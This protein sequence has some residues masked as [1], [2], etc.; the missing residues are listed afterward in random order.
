MEEGRSPESCLISPEVLQASSETS[1]LRRIC[2]EA[3]IH[4]IP[5]HK[6]PSDICFPKTPVSCSPHPD[7][8]NQIEVISSTPL[9]DPEPEDPISLMLEPE[10]CDSPQ[11][12]ESSDPLDVLNPSEIAKISS[13]ADLVR[14][15]VY[16]KIS[17]DPSDLTYPML[18]DT[19]ASRSLISD[20]VLTRLPNATISP[21]PIKALQGIG[22]NLIPTSEQVSLTLKFSGN[23]VCSP[24]DFIITSEVC[25]TYSL[26]LGADFLKKN[27]FL[28]DVDQKTLL[29]KRDD[30][31]GIVARDPRQ[32]TKLSF[33]CSA[34]ESL[35]ISP[36]SFKILPI[37]LELDGFPEFPGYR[38]LGEFEQIPELPV[39][40]PPGVVFLTPESQSVPVFNP[41]NKIRHLCKGQEIGFV[42][43]LP[44]EFM[45][46]CDSVATVS[47]APVPDSVPQIWTSSL[48]DENFHLSH[49]SDDQK[50]PLIKLLLKFPEAMSF[51]D[52]DVGT[53]SAIK[54]HIEVTDPKP[55]SLP[56]R[57]LTPNV[58]EEVDRECR[59]L[60]EAGIVQKSFSPYSAPIVPIRKPDG[61]LRLCIDYRQ[62]NRVTKKDKFPL[63]NLTDLIYSLH[64][65]KY[66][67]SIDLVRGYYQVLMDE[68][69]IE[70]TAFST[71][72][73]HLEFTR[74]PFGV[75]NGPATFQRGMAIALAG[76][77]SSRA[78]VYLDD[79]LVMGQ[80]FEDHLISLEMVLSAL[81]EHGFKL[82]P[83][84]TSLAL[85]E[86]QF[87]GHL[88]SSSGIKPLPKNLSG[89]QEFP[90]PNTVRQVR[91]FLGMVNFY[92]R[93]IPRCAEISKPL[94][95]ITGQKKLTWTNHCQEAFDQLKS[96][97]QSPILLTYPNFS[98]SDSP[99]EL[100][101]D[102]SDLGAG[103]VLSQTQESVNRPIAFVSCTFNPAQKRY[104]TTEKEL[105]AL[106]W[107]VK[108]LRVFLHGAKFILYTDHRPLIYLHNMKLES[109]RLA[110]TV[111]DLSEFDY[112]LRYTPGVTNTVADALSRNPIG[113]SESP[114]IICPNHPPLEFNLVPIPGGGNSLFTCLAQWKYRDPQ[115]HIDI[116]E[117]VF[118]KILDSPEKFGFTKKASCLRSLRIQRRSGQLVPEALCHVLSEVLEMQIQVY[119]GPTNPMVYGSPSVDDKCYLFCQA[120]I[121]YDLLYPTKF[122]TP[123]L[124][125]TS[126]TSPVEVLHHL[127]DDDLPSQDLDLNISPEKNNSESPVLFPEETSEIACIGSLSC[128]YPL[129]DE[130]TL[131]FHQKADRQVKELYSA[132][133][134]SL[135]VPNWSPRL[136]PFR[137]MSSRFEITDGL[138]VYRIPQSTS[139]PVIPRTLLIRVVTTYHVDQ[140]HLGRDKLVALIRAQYWSPYI[141][142]VISDICSACPTCQTTKIT[143]VMISPPM[144]KIQCSYPFEL[145]SMDLLNL[146]ITPRRFCCCL[147]IIDHF[148][149][150]LSVVPLT[151]KTSNSVVS[152]LKTRVLPSLPAIPNRILTDNGPEFSSVEFDS[153]LAQFGITHVLTTPYNPTSNGVVERV[154]RTV[155]QLLRSKKTPDWDL[156]LP[157]VII[158][159]NNTLHSE[160]GC[161]PN[162]LILT[163]EH[164]L[165][166]TPPVSRTRQ[167]AWKQGHPQYV[168][169]RVGQKVSR[170]VRQIGYLTKNK[171]NPKFEGPYKIVRTDPN[172]VTYVIQKDFPA[173]GNS[174]PLIRVHHRQLKNWVD[175]PRYLL[176]DPFFKEEFNKL[177]EDSPDLTPIRPAEEEDIDLESEPETE[178][179]DPPRDFPGFSSSMSPMSPEQYSQLQKILTAIRQSIP[180]PVI[181]NPVSPFPVSTSVPSIIDS[182]CLSPSI[183][184]PNSS[185]SETSFNSL[186]S[187]PLHRSNVPLHA[188]SYYDN[189]SL[190]LAVRNLFETLDSS[191]QDLETIS[192]SLRG[193]NDSLHS[194]EVSTPNVFDSPLISDLR[195]F[196]RSARDCIIDRRRLAEQRRAD[197]YT[198]LVERRRSLLP[199]ENPSSGAPDLMDWEISHSSSVEFSDS[200]SLSFP[201]ALFDS[202]PDDTSFLGFEVP[203]R[204]S[205]PIR[206][207]DTVV[208]TMSNRPF[209]RGQGRS[210]DLPCVMSH[211]LE[212]KPRSH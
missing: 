54:H 148:S 136:N 140:A 95:E 212:Y 67:S 92:R 124:T 110:R 161:S 47:E 13:H 186:L 196:I 157:E 159:Y 133:S 65:V 70:K 163:K 2:V 76:I 14:V 32:M 156:V 17:D 64:G 97:L 176:R 35:T 119:H 109:P 169:F 184:N 154:N 162:E 12:E 20:K 202:S 143:G 45:L 106:R 203:I 173:P 167:D 46:P 101:V 134:R 160:I 90:V 43:F 42:N 30:Q 93:H 77:P 66:F 27:K 127:E 5:S 18:V 7:F 123:D 50:T 52:H 158:S 178:E 168:P 122:T 153:L 103:A 4:H 147:V 85:P 22:P 6:M 49:L 193:V 37:Q 68:S 15:V 139:V 207:V 71:P 170:K 115:K 179:D 57:R 59:E 104:S 112:E 206:S 121:H 58:T 88:V 9:E 131:K 211:P 81:K 113:V 34:Q 26:L 151:D 181:F 144:L 21:S 75:C 83:K 39:E 87:L 69:S 25:T 198:Q 141:S 192:D 111:E 107:A 61:K 166:V 44:L 36:Q 116:R 180:T 142:E 177:L 16:G 182:T 165:Q 60:E 118:T 195:S 201:L 23:F 1:E 56:V 91:Q 94:S 41:S 210:V 102:A 145:V 150:W 138:L 3:E 183:P 74:L 8:F 146:P 31:Y 174:P 82:K 132:I 96:A 78:L 120:G 155:L 164:R 105:A 189:D 99:L 108:S 10:V 204:N 188:S 11:E 205:T 199:G 137:R 33:A 48:I 19:G 114:E 84:K 125:L 175:V 149:K 117:L 194:F 172:R 126:D 185:T 79:I 187:P 135:P 100:R 197:I 72:R 89:I 209:T 98:D 200:T 40:I 55:V 38:S 29:V 191:N 86:V 190:L 53:T 63:P 24:S 80:N 62:L 129:I 51:G 28:T 128:P 130:D 152:A 73:S 171:L 208:T